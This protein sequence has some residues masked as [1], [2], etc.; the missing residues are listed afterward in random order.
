MNFNL[1]LAPNDCPLPRAII[2][3]WDNT[4]IDSWGVIHA[5]L[6][7]T[8]EQMAIPAWSFDETKAKVRHSL[9]DSF[10]LVFGDSWELARQY[11]YQHF[12]SQHLLALKTLDGAEALLKSCQEH[13]IPTCIISNK[14]G[15]YLRKEVEALGWNCYFQSIVGAGDV[16]RDKPDPMVVHHAL[17]VLAMEPSP[18]IWFVGDTDVDLICAGRSGCLPVFVGDPDEF[19]IK[20]GKSS[21]NGFYFNDL[22][23]ISSALFRSKQLC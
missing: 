1:Q 6:M 13:N 21:V 9:R 4:L 7:A 20:D 5:S 11:Y 18:E 3:D 8:F 2:F 17:N 16:E 19:T 14:T 23:C 22:G 15:R 12:E 10:P